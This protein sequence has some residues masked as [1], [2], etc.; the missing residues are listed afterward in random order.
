MAITAG[1]NKKIEE[2]EGFHYGYYSRNGKGVT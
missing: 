2:T 1:M